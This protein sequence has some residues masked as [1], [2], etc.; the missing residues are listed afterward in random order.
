MFIWFWINILNLV[1]NLEINLGIII[2]FAIFGFSK[3]QK[4]IYDIYIRFSLTDYKF[5]LYLY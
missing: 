3:K 4:T 5:K 1:T 2:I